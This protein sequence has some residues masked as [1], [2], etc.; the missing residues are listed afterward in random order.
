M[1]TIGGIIGLSFGTAS[2]E[3]LGIAGPG[4]TLIAYSVNSVVAICVMEG[5]CKMIVL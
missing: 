1:I 5:L 4:G 2:G 3:I